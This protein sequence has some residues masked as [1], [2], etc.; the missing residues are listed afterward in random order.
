MISQDSGTDSFFDLNNKW[1]Y[2]RWWY[3]WIRNIRIHQML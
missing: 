2:Y 1:K 3:K